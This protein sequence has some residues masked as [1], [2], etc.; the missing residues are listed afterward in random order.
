[1]RKLVAGLILF[2]SAAWPAAA[3]DGG[4]KLLTLPDKAPASFERLA[5]G[6]IEIAT[7]GSV[8]FLYRTAPEDCVRMTWRWRVDKAGPAGDLMRKGQDDRPLAVHLW[9]ADESMQA[10]LKGTVA[11]LLGY[12]SYGRVLTYVW[13]PGDTK[14]KRFANPYMDDGQGAVIVLRDARDG[15]MTWRD[16]TVD[17]VADYVAAFGSMP[18]APAYVAVSGDSDDLGGMTLGR[19]ADLK[20]E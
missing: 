14:G 10:G 15:T 12:P 11:K 5:D 8:A 7:D 4:W 3:I 9:F 6:T 2:L 1:M 19:I 16:E 20:L 18:L 13:A 17:I